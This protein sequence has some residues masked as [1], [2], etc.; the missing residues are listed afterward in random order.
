MADLLAQLDE[1]DRQRLEAAPHPSWCEPVLAKLTD[2][3]FSDPAWLFERKFDGER[4]LAFRRG[5]EVR[6]LS[7]NRKSLNN[8]YPELVD[9]LTAQACHDFVVDGEVVAFDGERSSFAR[10][11]QRMQIDD[12]QAARASGIA[13]SYYLFDLLHLDGHDLRHLPLRRRKALLKRAIAFQ[14]PLRFTSHR[15]R[16]GEALFRDA[17]AKGWEGLI[18][19]RADA[20]YQG[21]RS[22]DWLKFKCA[23]GQELVI[24]G[25]SAARGSR[26]GFGALLLGYYD[27]DRLRYAGKVGTGFD[28]RTLIELRRR[29]DCLA[30][31]GSPFA[32]EVRDPSVTF[33][34]PKLVAEIGFTEWTADGRLRHPRFLGL[35]RD[36]RP[37]EVSR[38]RTEADGGSPR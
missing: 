24:A 1:R 11:Q 3:R 14:D 23:G 7:R 9:A 21:G 25:F 28:D 19:K 20:P 15:N 30:R 34:Q 36:K 35:R 12:P 5:T 37:E 2:E 33:V 29:L 31:T 13:V 17:C 27:D 4:A 32:D 8:S 26:K 10:L 38:E 22:T 18:A 16:D 6:L